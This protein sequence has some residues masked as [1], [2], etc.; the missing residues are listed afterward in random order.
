GT[1]FVPFHELGHVAAVL[2]GRLD[3]GDAGQRRRDQHLLGVRLRLPHVGGGAVAADLED[4]DVGGGGAAL[5]VVGFLQ[6]LQL[7]FRFLEGERVLLGLDLRKHVVLH[8]LESRLLLRALRLRERAVVAGARRHFLGL[9]LLDLL[10]EVGQLGAPIQRVAQLLLAIELD[11]RIARL[12]RAPVVDEPHD[13]QRVVVL[14]RQPR[15]RDAGRLDG[16]HRAAQAHAADE[17]LP[18]DGRRLVRPPALL[19]EARRRAQVE[20]CCAH[21][22]EG[23]GRGQDAGVHHGFVGALPALSSSVIRRYECPFG[24]A[25]DRIPQGP[26]ASW[27]Y[28]TDD[29][30]NGILDTVW[31]ALAGPTGASPRS[32]SAVARERRIRFRRAEGRSAAVSSGWTAVKCRRGAGAARSRSARPRRW[33]RCRRTPLAGCR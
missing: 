3:H 9:A 15:R 27:G 1:H 31:R 5:E 22:N 10:L 6:L 33:W 2:P 32:R 28:V 11:Q 29:S 17:V 25:F 16:L 13:H 26:S 20:T 23:E 8:E 4:P 30:A 12:D 7:G 14:P 19:L 21:A 18:L 24:W